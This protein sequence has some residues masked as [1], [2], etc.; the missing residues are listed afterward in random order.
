VLALG[1]LDLA[2]AWHS[3]DVPTIML[4][5]GL[6]VVSAQFRL[7]GFY[8][9]LTRRI[10]GLG[11]SPAT[12]LAQSMALA[13]VLSALLAND[14]ICLAI[15]PVL[16]E[17]CARRRLNPMPHLVGLACA[18]NIGSAATLIGNPQNMLIGQV[19]RLSFAVYTLEAL[20]PTL[21]ALLAAWWIIA[22][23]YRGRW[24]LAF[25]CAQLE[26]PPFDR[27]QTGK[28]LLVLGVIVVLFLA[29]GVPRELVAL[30][31][32]GVLLVS[33][34]LASPRFLSLVDW[35]LLVLFIGLFIINHAMQESGMVAAAVDRLRALGVNLDRAPWLLAVTAILSNLVS[36]V[37]AV[38]LLLGST[39]HPDAGLIL[40]LASTFA[41]NFIL[42]GSIAN[43][44]VAEQAGRV[45]VR[46]DA[47]EHARAG[48]PVTLASLAI[49]A[50]WIAAL[51]QLQ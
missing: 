46:F 31:A 36:N 5:F 12:F 21:L 9:E 16:A 26:S 45:G 33:R 35:N 23:L 25:D 50:A 10:K 37:P 13:A 51:G 34:R 18:S 42:L 15:T 30:G 6:M 44:I 22:R 4:L 47:W 3:V 17:I 8:T 24:E 49:T 11:G 19:L 39:S 1:R 20:V 38:M 40:A 14:I 41:G 48:I 2:E 32:A 7:G 27:W 43:I 29:G 28:G